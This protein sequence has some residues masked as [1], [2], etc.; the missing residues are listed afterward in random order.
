MSNAFL[1]NVNQITP[2]GT[3]NYEQSGS[4]KWADPYTG[5][6]YDIPRFT[7]TQTLSPQQQAIKA[8]TDAAELNLGRLANSQSGRLNDVLGTPFSLGG[9][10]QG[11][12][13]ANI[14]SPQYQQFAGGPQLQTQVDGVGPVTNSYGTEYG[15][16]VQAVQDALMS[17]LQP[18]L[19]RDRQALEQRLANQGI[20]IGS[21]A[22]QAAMDD[23]GRTSNDARTSTLLAA[24]QEQS[25]LA[26]LAQAQ[27]Q[28]QNSA[29][30]QTYDQ[31]M[32]R[33]G[34][35]NSANQQMFDNQNR[36]TGQNNQLQDQSMNAQL[37]QF[38]AANTQRNQALNE[39]FATRNQPIN[40]IS[41]LLSGSQVSQP[42]F[43]NAN[44]PTIP[45]TDTAGIIN[46]EY[47]QRLG[48]WQQEQAQRQNILG[49]LFGLGSAGIFKWS[50]KRLKEDVEKVGETNDGQNIYSYRYKGDPTP[51]MGLMA[52]EV[53]KKRPSAVRRS[54]SGLMA[55]DYDRALKGAK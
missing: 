12:N 48:I 19:D 54:K 27:A 35:A 8:Q 2:D 16:N 5:Q 47:N 20:Q 6:S 24:G 49:G 44:M 32:G 46:N 11:G 45:T 33:A 9:L 38:N 36:V 42:N 40:E 41:A 14:T 10:P 21:A 51:Q 34:L 13:A 7:A 39:Q 22:Y 25:R 23:Y 4:Y 1:G 50:D 55:V 53:A 37:A 52:Q 26:G 30:Q 15:A 17:R 28:F 3:L 29:Q 31:M 18:S 43:V